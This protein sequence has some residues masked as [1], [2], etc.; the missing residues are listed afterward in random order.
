M[1]EPYYEQDGVTIYHGDCLNVLSEI[2]SGSVSVIF[3]D[4]PYSSGARQAATIRARAGMSR[5]TKVQGRWFGTDNLTSHGFSML[6]RMLAVEWLRVTRKDGHLL[7]FIDW[8][9]W[10]T[11]AGAIES[12]GWGIRA[13]LVWDK[14][15]FGM[16]NGFRQQCEFILHASNGTGDNFARHDL[17]TVFRSKRGAWSDH[18]TE[19]P[20]GTTGEIL[21]ALP[22]GLVLDPFM[23]SGTTL[24]AASAQGRKAIGIEIEERYCEIAAKRLAQGVL[25][26]ED[27]EVPA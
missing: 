21:S 13:C 1:K 25:P 11:L 15:H 7:S 5:T 18:P 4:P 17:G 6:V 22:N 9:Q 16:G 14:V 20:E 10:P 12:A 8:R 24:V 3:T 26:F 2:Q 27:S 23:G 19:K